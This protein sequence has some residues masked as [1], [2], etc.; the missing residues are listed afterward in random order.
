MSV[1][2]PASLRLAEA[3][4]T[5]SMELD[6]AR[7]GSAAQA[8]V[9]PVNAVSLVFEVALS[10][11]SAGASAGLVATVAS[12]GSGGAALGART[13]WVRVTLLPPRE[14]T[15]AAITARLADIADSTPEGSGRGDEE[16]VTLGQWA[17]RKAA[18]L[19][20]GFTA[21]SLR[22]WLEASAASA[23]TEF[24]ARDCERVVTS[25]GKR[26]RLTAAVREA[27]VRRMSAQGRLADALNG[28]R[29]EP[30]DVGAMMAEAYLRGTAPSLD[31][32]SAEQLQGTLQAIEWLGPAGIDLPGSEEVRRHLPLAA[33]LGPL[34]LLV[35]D[36]FIGRAEELRR[37][38]DY[39]EILPASSLRSQVTRGVRRV[40][41]LA[42]KPPLV[43]HGPGGVGKSTLVARFALEHAELGPERRFPFAYL[44]FDRGDLT[45]RQ[46]LTL[47]AEAAR[48]LGVLFP[49][50]GEEA[51][52][53]E[54]AIGSALIVQSAAEQEQ[55]AL[56]RSSVSTIEQT[57]ADERDLVDRFAQLID[58]AIHGRD[59][60]SL[61]LLDTFEQAQ[62]YGS[63]AVDRLW[64]FLD[65]L[66]A[67]LPRQRTVFS[68]RA[69]IDGRPTDELYLRGFDKELALGF[70]RAELPATG[71]SDRILE[72]VTSR[73]GANPLSLKLAAEVLRREGETGLR[74][75]ETRRMVIFR[76][77]TEEIQGLLYRRILDHLDDPDLRRIA[78]PG[79]VV[80]RITPEIITDVLA[81]PCGLGPVDSYR[82]R[83]LFEQLAREV[84]LVEVGDDD[85]LVHRPDIRRTMLPMI[86]E[87]DPERARSIHRRAVRFYQQQPGVRARAEELYHRLALG[88]ATR[89][90]DKYW[91]P[92]AAALLETALDELPPSSRVYLAD[93]LGIALDA[94]T[95]TAA[96]DDTWSRQASR[97]ARKLLD[98]GRP[99]EAL[100]LLRQR[101]GRT[102]WPQVAALEIEALA[103]LGEAA[104][105]LELADK[106]L[107]QATDDG[108]VADFIE[109]VMTGA[110]I[111]E[112]TGRYEL[113]L[114]WLGEAVQAAEAAE[115]RLAELAAKVALLRVHRRASVSDPG[116]DLGLLRGGVLSQ[117]GR[118]SRQDRAH[119]PSLVRD[120]AA[121]VGADAPVLL[122]EAARLVGVDLDGQAG[123]ILA[124]LVPEAEMA[125]FS[126]FEFERKQFPISDSTS[127]ERYRGP[128]TGLTAIEHG[129]FISDY[130]GQQRDPSPEWRTA[131]T[132]AFQ[133]EADRPA[134][135]R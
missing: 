98:S 123:N 135:R 14:L 95:L 35:G 70:L 100:S 66:Q 27:T 130:L 96:D 36:H 65:Q 99:E 26:W 134:F 75:V 1:R 104:D 39:V 25:A 132:A 4:V 47:L 117:A 124:R 87:H 90:L 121:E 3:I 52:S 59:Q 45:P 46:P 2:L 89:T 62:R 48:Q 133:F 110:R 74:Q 113:A 126:A 5:M 122:A 76:L 84:S 50:V 82:A 20:G 88:Q 114:R 116:V 7:R 41:R 101:P 64:A 79:L 103:V 44:S 68:G 32:Q 106:S 111:A 15:E 58:T 91:D 13:P 10:Q 131:L 125:R 61:W 77:G 22:P 118:L 51:R 21:G 85:A 127:T 112:D 37:L 92:A 6:R 102:V 53:L 40:L 71:F 24:V 11:P 120:L 63:D 56:A 73:V 69:P 86:T 54:Q 97:T 67:A 105:A 81:V 107:T 38:A 33:L 128:V 94:S 42:E 12:L 72:S 119:N 29:P 49:A 9:L 28:V 8:A 17:C 129:A 30:F 43:I 83:Q 31:H 16:E 55:S 34:R 19:L 108:R 57:Q 23:L 109:M 80:R 115:D 18:V 93:R 78:N 60:P